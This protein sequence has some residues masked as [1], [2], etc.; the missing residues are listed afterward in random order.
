[1][2]DE[3]KDFIYYKKV[4]KINCLVVICQFIKMFVK[5]TGEFQWNKFY[6]MFIFLSFL[7]FVKKYYLVGI[8]K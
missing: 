3:K 2:E 4:L 5:G 1:M 6:N 8:D 7:V